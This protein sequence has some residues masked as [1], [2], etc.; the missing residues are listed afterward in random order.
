E[1]PGICLDGKVWKECSDG[2]ASCAHLDDEEDNRTC[3]PG[4]YC[5]SGEL[6]LNNQCVPPSQCPCTENGVLYE[7]GETVLRDF[8]ASRDGSRIARSSSVALLMGTGQTGHH[9]A[10]VP[11]RVGEG[12]RTGTDSAP[13]PLPP[14]PVCPVKVLS[15]RSGPVTRSRVMKLVPGALGAAGRTVPRRAER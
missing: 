9:G 4:C 6:L 14:E 11:L 13:S 5:Q 3:Q 7:P 1:D 2:P 8:P 15:G 10:S 12:S